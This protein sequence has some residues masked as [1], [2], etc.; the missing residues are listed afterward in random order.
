MANL[1][2]TLST[3]DQVTAAIMTAIKDRVNER[4][5]KGGLGT[6]I[7]TIVSEGLAAL[8]VAEGSRTADQI[9]AV[10]TYNAF[11]T[12]L[13]AGMPVSSDAGAKYASG[14]QAQSEGSRRSHVLA[15]GG[16]ATAPGSTA[17]EG[18]VPVE[19]ATP[20]VFNRRAT[21]QPT[22]MTWQTLRDGTDIYRAPSAV[23]L[24][25]IH[26]P[27]TMTYGATVT[28]DWGDAGGGDINAGKA[29]SNYLRYTLTGDIAFGVAGSPGTAAF[30]GIA[31]LQG[32]DFVLELINSANSART[33]SMLG[34]PGTPVTAGGITVTH[35]DDAINRGIAPTTGARAWIAGRIV[36]AS[37]V[38]ITSYKRT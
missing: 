28:V 9:A 21:A 32:M 17:A 22:V 5:D 38:L 14:L 13:T 27:Q 33:I 2:Y 30:A 3:G 37:E 16:I 23:F 1:T 34:G 24:K 29:R 31:N 11:L 20:G 26:A 25:S 19:S 15:M 36:G 4:P 8:A 7:S 12:G 35:C 6:M 10:T 18:S